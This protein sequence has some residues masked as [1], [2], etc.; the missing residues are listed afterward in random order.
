MKFVVLIWK[1]WL[2][3]SKDE[4][5][6]WM[7]YVKAGNVRNP[8]CVDKIR[9]ATDAAHRILRRATAAVTS[10]KPCTLHSFTW[11]V[12][13]CLFASRFFFYLYPKLWKSLLFHWNPS[14]M[15]DLVSNSKKRIRSHS[16]ETPFTVQSKHFINQHVMEKRDANKMKQIHGELQV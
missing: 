16:N 10:C 11:L 2:P 4:Y 1:H 6:N 13:I 8:Q 14:K 7:K 15:T 9:A 3:H 5:S 12:P